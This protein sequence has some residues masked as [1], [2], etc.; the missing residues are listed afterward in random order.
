MTIAGVRA[1]AARDVGD[2]GRGQR[3]DEQHVHTHRK[4]AGGE[5]VLEHVTGEARVLAEHD[6]V[7][8]PPR[9]WDSRF[10]KT[11][12]AA[13]PSLS[14]VSAVTGST[15]ARPRTPSVPKIF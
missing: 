2:A 15:F 5:R 8:G 10:L 4:D 11:W 13:R 14:A 3:A 1:Q 7:P 6:L 12:A 9:D